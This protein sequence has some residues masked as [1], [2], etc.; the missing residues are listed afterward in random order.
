MET[1]V[2]T[3]GTG[4]IGRTLS[5]MLVQKNYRVIVLSRK[6]VKDSNGIQ[7]ASWNPEKQIIDAHVISKADHIINL[8]GAGV[9]DK[10]WTIK[11]KK[12]IVES[13]VDSGRV[14]VKALKEILN[15]VQTVVSASGIGWYGPDRTNKKPFVESDPAE[16]DFLGQTCVKWEHS[17][18]PVEELGKRLVILRTGIVLSKEG[19]ALREFIKPLKAGVTTILGSGKQVISWIHIIDICRVYIAAIEQKHMYGVYNACAAEWVT[20]KELVMKL[21]KSRSRSFIP[22][23]VPEFMLKVVLGEMSIE[24]LKSTTVDNG[25]LRNAG[26]SFVFPTIDAAL[27]DVSERE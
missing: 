7:Y 14:I 12:E 10:R 6:K 23:H 18:S 20:N 17:V 5:K 9:A 19:G 16:N 2:I 8:A 4:L 27:K 13:R 25:K 15:N 3:G 21:A 26:F 11:R 22:V 24:V 1:V